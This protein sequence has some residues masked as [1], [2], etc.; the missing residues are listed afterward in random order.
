MGGETFS[1]RIDKSGVVRVFWEGLCVTTVG[2]AR[3]SKLATGL[4]NADPRRTQ[5]LLQRGYGKVLRAK[6]YN[7]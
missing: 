1:Y 6:R 2:G 5:R 3:A 4:K 7:T